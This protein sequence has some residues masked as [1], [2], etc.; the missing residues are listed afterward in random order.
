[1]SI[2]AFLFLPIEDTPALREW[3]MVATGENDDA[4]VKDW[5]DDNTTKCAGCGER[6]LHTHFDGSAVQEVEGRD[7]YWCD[8]CAEDPDTDP[9][10]MRRE[11]GTYRAHH[12][13]VV[14]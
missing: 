10:D 3:I 11:H 7:G 1:M 2:P 13:H 6:F 9:V 8:A 4:A 5:M 12:G 14:G